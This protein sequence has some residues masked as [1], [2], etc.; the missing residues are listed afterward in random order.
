[1]IPWPRAWRLGP[2]SRH[3][4]IALLFVCASAHAAPRTIVVPAIAS[5]HGA[6]GTFF[7]S[8]VHLFNHSSTR[9]SA[10]LT[11]RCWSGQSCG[12]PASLVLEPRSNRRIE[13]VVNTLF[14]TPETAGALEIVYDDAA[15]PVTVR[16]RMYT[17]G[18][19]Q[20]I[21]GLE[22]GAAYRISLLNFVPLVAAMRSNAG[23][24]NPN[25]APASTTWELHRADGSLIRT[26]MRVV[27]ARE[28]FQFLVSGE[29][30][31]PGAYF[32]VSSDLPIFT[33]VSA[34]DNQTGDAVFVT[35]AQDARSTA[36]AEVV[37]EC[38]QYKFSPGSGSTPIVL[39]AGTSYR[40]R[41]HSL[42][43]THGLSAIQQLGI[44]GGDIL[45][46]TDY[47]VDVSVPESLRGSRF[48]FA[49]TRLCGS[50]H[51]NMYGAIEVR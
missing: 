12:S 29:T 17:N 43:T 35:A 21:P 18:Y 39:V 7:R 32:I 33:Y 16:S 2:R 31:E 25:D 19:G 9:V 30:N 14:A 36:P 15:G 46:D 47:V 41:F 49:C 28:S 24:Y 3:L 34:V 26:S 11:F 13:D 20:G 4:L 51:G 45:P 1:M 40:L 23:A 8:D 37:V 50:G 44:A 48:N 22:L 6:G 10:Q 42:D 38:S 5:I 27:V